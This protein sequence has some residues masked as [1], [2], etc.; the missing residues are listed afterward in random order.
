[1]V[2]QAM[3]RLQQSG[4]QQQLLLQLVQAASGQLAVQRLLN[5]GN[6]VSHYHMML[7]SLLKCYTVQPLLPACNHAAAA[8]KHAPAWFSIP[9]NPPWL[10]FCS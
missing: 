10:H 6:D 2:M 7:A 3:Q 9:C 8:A 4:Q 1:M 5:A